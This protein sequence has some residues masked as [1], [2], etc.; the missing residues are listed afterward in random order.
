MSLCGRCK[1]ATGTF[2]EPQRADDVKLA[3]ENVL[4]L[5][6]VLLVGLREQLEGLRS[7]FVII[8]EE[9]TTSWQQTA[10]TVCVLQ[11]DIDQPLTI[12]C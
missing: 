12:T 5:G 1:L 6:N 11:G 2:K 9:P 3:W 8:G 4:H 10:G 7:G